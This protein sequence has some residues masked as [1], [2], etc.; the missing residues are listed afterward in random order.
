MAD[1]SSSENHF[2]ISKLIGR[3][4]NNCFR[5]TFK[6]STFKIRMQIAKA[7]CHVKTGQ[8]V[9][10]F[11]FLQ[12]KGPSLAGKRHTDFIKTEGSAEKSH[13][14]FSWTGKNPFL[15]GDLR[16]VD[17]GGVSERKLRGGVV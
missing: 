6:H 9:I 16:N 14:N 7:C 3:T 15:M 8:S 2:I 17:L 12:R 5:E 10:C 11:W 13:G 1:Q 4:H